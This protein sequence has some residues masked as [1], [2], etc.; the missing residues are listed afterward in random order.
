VRAVAAR[1]LMRHGGLTQRE[2]AVELGVGT[3][4]AVGAQLDRLR[5]GLGDNHALARKVRALETEFE[6][7]KKDAAKC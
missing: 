1:M 3:G 2:V 4:R 7:I 5:Q 6:Q